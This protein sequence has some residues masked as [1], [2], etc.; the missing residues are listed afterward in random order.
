MLR[1]CWGCVNRV[2]QGREDEGADS[3][4]VFVGCG[5]VAGGS[6]ESCCCAALVLLAEYETLR[7]VRCTG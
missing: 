7:E 4:S 2:L 3:K 6:E 5:A 1:R